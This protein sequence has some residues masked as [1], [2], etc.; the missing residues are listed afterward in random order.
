MGTVI[1]A[2]VTGL[3]KIKIKISANT[4]KDKLPNQ[5]GVVYCHLRCLFRSNTKVRCT[6]RWKKPFA[7]YCDAD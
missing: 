3:V 2:K 5:T 4:I 6:L 1:T 7:P